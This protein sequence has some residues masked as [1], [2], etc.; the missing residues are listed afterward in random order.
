[1]LPLRLNRPHGTRWVFTSITAS[2][3][4]R[5]EYHDLA[6]K[7]GKIITVTKF[8]ELCMDFPFNR[9][10]GTTLGGGFIFLR[11]VR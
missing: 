6:V 4:S 10:P 8:Y 2:L 5:M 3:L 1:M 7:A 9:A 11:I